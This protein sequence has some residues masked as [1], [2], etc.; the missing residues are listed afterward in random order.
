MK[1]TLIVLTSVALFSFGA[2]ILPVN[3]YFAPI[4]HRHNIKIQLIRR[5]KQ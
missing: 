4:K 1:K 3:T 2:G 5:L